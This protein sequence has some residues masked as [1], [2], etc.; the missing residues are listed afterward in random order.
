MTCSRLLSVER[1]YSGDS[2]EHA[3]RRTEIHAGWGD[4]VRGRTED[5]LGPITGHVHASLCRLC[6]THHRHVFPSLVEPMGEEM[7]NIFDL[8]LMVDEI[9]CPRLFM[10]AHSHPHGKPF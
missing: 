5:S 9:L 7:E 8:F 4:D 3:Q 2:L 6:S 10:P 1:G